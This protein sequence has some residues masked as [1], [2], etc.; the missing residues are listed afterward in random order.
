MEVIASAVSSIG[1][2]LGGI[3]NKKALEKQAGN[4]TLQTLAAYQAQKQ[5]L[6]LQEAQMALARQAEAQQQKPVQNRTIA[7][8]GIALLGLMGWQVFKNRNNPSV[9]QNTLP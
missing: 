1:N 5:E 8:V 3:A 7:L 9:N 4:Q 2:A 6:A